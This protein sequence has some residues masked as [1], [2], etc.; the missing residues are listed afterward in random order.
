MRRC[1]VCCALEMGVAKAAVAALGNQDALPWRGEVSQQRLAVFGK[2]L[3]TRRNFDVAVVAIGTS[4]VLAHAAPASLS[5]VVL[6]V[7]VVDQR[8]E[9]VDA[10]DEDTATLSA[11]AAVGS[12]EL[13]KLL[14]AEADAAVAACSGRDVDFGL[15]EKLHDAR[16][17]KAVVQGRRRS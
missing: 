1:L 2:N 13:N 17:F 11:V 15:I 14:A 8:V 7:A 9:V 5:F 4:A 16:A 12:A 10:F 3:S 6:L